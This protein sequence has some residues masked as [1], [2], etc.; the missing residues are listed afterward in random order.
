MT[1]VRLNA[2]IRANIVE[3]ALKHRFGDTCLEIVEEHGAIANAVYHAQFTPKRLAQLDALPDDWCDHI[4]H[5]EGNFGGQRHTFWF[6]GI[7]P[8]WQRETYEAYA[9]IPAALNTDEDRK[10][11]K[12][13]FLGPK[14]V[15]HGGQAITE[16]VRKYLSTVEKFNEAH[17][18]VKH[19][20]EATLSQY[21]MLNALVKA[22]PE[23]EQFVPKVEKEI[24][25]LPVI[26]VAE[27]NRMLELAA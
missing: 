1:A 10:R 18:K 8:R 15:F 3:A 14:P 9:K 26:P 7:H 27:L 21:T 19:T 12:R 11:W 20:I 22:W 6:C 23:I 16:R 25:Q 13:R 5:V 4:E 17:K 2:L 24:I